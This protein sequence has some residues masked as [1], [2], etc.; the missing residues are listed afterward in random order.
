MLFMSLWKS[1]ANFPH[2]LPAIAEKILINTE[3]NSNQNRNFGSSHRVFIIVNYRI[4]TKLKPPCFVPVKFLSSANFNC[5]GATPC[6]RREQHTT[7]NKKA[8]NS[9]ASSSRLTQGIP[10]ISRFKNNLKCTIPIFM[11]KENT[12]SGKIIWNV[13]IPRLFIFFYIT[14]MS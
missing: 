14:R 6:K 2:I 3:I 12:I 10:L 9:V 11:L 5:Y 4:P 8:T 7:T 1:F 13:T